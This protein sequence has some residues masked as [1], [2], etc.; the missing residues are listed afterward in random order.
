[1]KSLSSIA[2]EGMKSW[3]HSMKVDQNKSFPDIP[4][5]MD[6]TNRPEN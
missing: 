4:A 5:L 1:M 6:K 3:I 2:M